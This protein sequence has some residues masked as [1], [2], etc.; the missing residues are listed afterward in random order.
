MTVIQITNYIQTLDKRLA[1]YKTGPVHKSLLKHM[2]VAVK[3]REI[4]R[5]NEVLSDV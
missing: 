1:V 3:V 4:Q 5:G 2:E